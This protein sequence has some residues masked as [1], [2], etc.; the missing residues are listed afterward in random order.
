LDPASGSGAMAGE[1]LM[2]FLIYALGMV[3]LVCGT[4]L[5]KVGGLVPALVGGFLS[6]AA[7]GVAFW[8]GRVS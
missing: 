6:G 2:H 3:L 4:T 7:F 8:A 5:I 1:P